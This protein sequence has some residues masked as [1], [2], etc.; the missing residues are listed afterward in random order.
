MIVDRYFYGRLP[1][2]EKQVY[3]E[4]YQGCMEHK[5]IIPLSATEEEISKSYARIMSAV[6]DDNPLLYFVNQS[7]SSFAIDE[8]GNC[9]VAPQYFFSQENV[10]KYNQ[11]IQDAANKLIMD[12]KLTEGSDLDKV[13]KV[14]DY[15]CAN[16][17]YDYDGANINDVTRFITAHNII[18]VFA[19]KKAQC[20]GIAKAA[21]VLLNAVDVKCIFVT[22][23]AKGLGTEIGDHGWNIVNI[24]GDPYQLDITYDIGATKD[25]YISYDYFNITDTQIRKN[26][27][28]STGYPKCTLHGASF[29]ETNDIVFSSKKKLQDYIASKI[30]AGEKMV[31]FKLGGK[32][33]AGDIWEEMMNYGYQILCDMGYGNM[34]GERIIND[35]INTCRIIYK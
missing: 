16:V 34:T 1:E 31:Y 24:D 27:V 7:M 9:A 29:F 17:Q 10:A 15:M 20:E 5:D 12:L 26:H 25:G 11:K 3:K 13:R 21:K 14:H 6:T 22:G 19:H 35:D 23:K 8:N 2:N 32:L 4:I 28:F 33:K 30:K 18:G